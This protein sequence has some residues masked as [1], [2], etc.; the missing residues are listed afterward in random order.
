MLLRAYSYLCISIPGFISRMITL[1]YSSCILLQL[2]E[3]IKQGSLK[4]GDVGKVLCQDLS[5]HCSP[6]RYIWIQ[7][8]YSSYSRRGT[9]NLKC[10]LLGAGVKTC[11]TGQIHVNHCW[12]IL[13]VLETFSL[14][15]FKQPHVSIHLQGHEVIVHQENN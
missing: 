14:V 5:R 6:S 13:L 1:T 10:C 7:N 15:L 8:C 2:A 12:Q 3:L 4:V 11:I 9:W